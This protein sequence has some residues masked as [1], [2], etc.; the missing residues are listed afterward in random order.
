MNINDLLKVAVAARIC[1]EAVEPV[2]RGVGERGRRG[3][4]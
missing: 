3:G 2:R 1:L 4:G